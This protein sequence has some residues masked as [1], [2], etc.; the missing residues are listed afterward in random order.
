[1]RQIG[2][3]PCARPSSQQQRDPRKARSHIS[4][5]SI[6]SSVAAKPRAQ[7]SPA[8]C[9]PILRLCDRTGGPCEGRAAEADHEHGHQAT[10]RHSA[11]AARRACAGGMPGHT[12]DDLARHPRARARK[13]HDARSA[14]VCGAE[15]GSE[16]R[17]ADA[18]A[19]VLAQ[20]GRSVERPRTSSSST[21][22]SG[23]RRRS[24][25]PSTGRASR[26]VGTIAGDD[27]CLVVAANN[28]MQPCWRAS[29]AISSASRRRPAVLDGRPPSQT[30][31]E[32]ET[33]SGLLALEL[34]LATWYMVRRSCRCVP[35]RLVGLHDLL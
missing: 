35:L 27:T 15:R 29:S 8:P 32:P 10:R 33:Q 13:A 1:M 28:R 24:R 21:P 22:S 12:G 31:V 26:I 23:R 25:G 19:G 16:H 7:N 34:V 3:P 20:F 5:R 9:I 30:A 2:R 14:T 11:R 6:R 18:L 17:S 4:F